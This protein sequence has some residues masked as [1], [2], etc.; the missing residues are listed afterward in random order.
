MHVSMLA[1]LSANA[2][3]LVS[4]RLLKLAMDIGCV[5]S[6]D[7][8]SHAPGQLDFLGYSAQRALDASSLTAPIAARLG[9]LVTCDIQGDRKL[10][11]CVAAVQSGGSGRRFDG[12]R[13]TPVRQH[14]NYPDLG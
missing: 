9:P 2:S 10:E 1:R 3:E 13:R 12:A 4:I 5:F 7:T 14:Q 11:R 6:I 8:D